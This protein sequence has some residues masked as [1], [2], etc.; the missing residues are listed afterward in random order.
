MRETVRKPQHG[1]DDWLMLRHRDR[2][3]FAI[4]AASEAAAVH[5]EHKYISKYGLAVAKMADKPVAAEANRAMD[6]G[7]R[8]EPVLLSWLGDQLGVQLSEPK[9]MYA[10]YEHGLIAT[11]DGIDTGSCLA[12]AS[13]PVVVA[14]IKTY[15]R[16]WRG[17]LPRHWYWQGVQQA[18]CA[19]VDKIYWGIFDS[20]LDLHV[21]LQEVT[22]DEKL[23]HIYAVRE[24]LEMVHANE[25]PAEWPA[26]Y[27][28][29]SSMYPESNG[30]TVDLT[31]QAELFT[32]LREVQAAKKLAAEEE[33]EL[34]VAIGQLL[35]SN[36]IGVVDGNQVVSWKPQSRKSFD[37]KRFQADHKDLYDQYQTS[38][39]FRVMR[40]KGE[41]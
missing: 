33:E 30:D 35:G 34:K 10:A 29:I 11:L 41:K 12:D 17:V 27:D 21:H 19:G 26:T 15:N 28:E 3:G 40:F 24:F 1:S 36:E 2:D 8:L 6:R 25:I 7:N 22:D 38:S 32:R 31:G 37:S 18:I 20:T 16:E 39:S 4:V 14:E 5:G 13:N 9:V 23:E